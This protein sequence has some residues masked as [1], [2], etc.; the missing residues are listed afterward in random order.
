MIS[1]WGLV[2]HHPQDGVDVGQTLFELP[3]LRHSPPP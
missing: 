3:P 1:S 2:F